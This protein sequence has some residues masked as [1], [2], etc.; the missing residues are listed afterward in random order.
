MTSMH[1]Q[2]VISLATLVLFAAS[3]FAVNINGTVKNRSTGKLSS[4][5]TVDLLALQQG[6]TVMASTKTDAS[7]AFHFEVSD[8]GSP[9]LI[10]VNHD[11]VGYFPAE[12]PLRPGATSVSIDVYDASDKVQ[13]V[14]TTVDI[15]RLQTDSSNLQ[16]MELFALKN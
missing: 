7:G 14:T 11:G 10:R 1:R 4:G 8:P 12:G 6:M 9:H 3:A 5:D 13:G 15:L 2:T 16:V